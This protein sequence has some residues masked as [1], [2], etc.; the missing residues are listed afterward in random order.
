MI[1]ATRYIG[2]QRGKLDYLFFLLTEDYIEANVKIAESLSPLL[3]QFARD[4]GD[5]GALVRPFS[6]E[7]KNTLGDALRKG[8]G[9]EEI[10][11][12]RRNLP[13]ILMTDVDFDDFDPTTNK[14]LIIYL[15][16]SMNEH[17]EV[18]IFELGELLNEL[19]LGARIKDLFAVASDYLEHQRKKGLKEASWDAVEL[20]PGAF[21]IKVDLKKGI[22]FLKSLRR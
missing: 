10:E 12:M 16:E 3:V 2:V 15:R 11:R 8:W 5:S 21:G 19:V 13:A 7:E 14:H 22:E 6:G 20:K 4:L 9:N 1:V 18:K 17:G